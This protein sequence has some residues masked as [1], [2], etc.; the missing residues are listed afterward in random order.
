M[1]ICRQLKYIEQNEQKTKGRQTA[2]QLGTASGTATFVITL[3]IIA[4]YSSILEPITQALQAVQFDIIGFQKT[5]LI[6]RHQCSPI[7]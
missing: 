5:T 6:I 7:I 3:H 4:K 2:H 1:E